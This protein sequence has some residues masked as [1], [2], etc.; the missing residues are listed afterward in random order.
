[1]KYSLVND[2]FSLTKFGHFNPIWQWR[3]HSKVRQ[4]A[5]PFAIASGEF[6]RK[7]FLTKESRKVCACRGSD[8]GGLPT[9]SGRQ[10]WNC[11]LWRYAVHC[12]HV[13]CR[14]DCRPTCHWPNSSCRS[15]FTY[16]VF[17]WLASSLLLI[18]YDW[19]MWYFETE[20]ML[21][22]MAYCAVI[23]VFNCIIENLLQ[24]DFH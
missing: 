7:L 12:A 4:Q 15:T 17:Q 11:R 6:L 13:H 16:G 2:F 23:A 22:V 21:W 9:F 24:D 8:C 18:L 5:K 10:T 20:N 14:D 3:V 1:M 19:A